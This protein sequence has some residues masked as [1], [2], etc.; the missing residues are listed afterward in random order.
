[1]GEQAVFTKPS[2]KELESKAGQVG[3]VHAQ[4]FLGRISA[5]DLAD[6]VLNQGIRS[7][8]RQA[9]AAA[10]ADVGDKKAMKAA[11]KA[12]YLDTEE[13]IRLE[14]AMGVPQEAVSWECSKL[15]SGPFKPC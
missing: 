14:R 15:R 3:L 2:L 9:Y 5:A 13:T 4:A 8:L 7:D 6:Y 1:M 11:G 10:V 12:A